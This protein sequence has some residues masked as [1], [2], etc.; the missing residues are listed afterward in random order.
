[1]GGTR[2]F[3]GAQ[4][5]PSSVAPQQRYRRVGARSRPRLG[6]SHLRM[7][8]EIPH[9]KHGNCISM[10]RGNWKKS[11]RGYW[12]FWYLTPGQIVSGKWGVWGVRAAKWPGRLGPRHAAAAWTLSLL[13]R[14]G[15]GE[16]PCKPLWPVWRRVSSTWIDIFMH[17]VSE[18]QR[19]TLP[20]EGVLWFETTDRP[21]TSTPEKIL[22]SG[23]CGKL[24]LSLSFPSLSARV[25]DW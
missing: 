9:W 25:A 22:P 13:V 2:L 24:A 12:M 20:T 11:R 1:M 19:W 16:G 18:R 10:A 3:G 6:F 5:E 15:N 21:K 23:A 7:S 17:F 4:A 14:R 8:G